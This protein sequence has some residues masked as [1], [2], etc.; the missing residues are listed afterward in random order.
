MSS[1]SGIGS[2]F[3]DRLSFLTETGQDYKASEQ[4][5]SRLDNAENDYLKALGDPNAS[6]GAVMQK[7][8]TYQKT[9]MIMQAF[10]QMIQNKYQMLRNI[11]QNGLSVR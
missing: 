5:G 1:P 7:Q 11:V 4:I 6:Q 10:Q 9:Q 3:N 8:I 2:A